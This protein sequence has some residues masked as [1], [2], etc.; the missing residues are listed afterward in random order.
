M[1]RRGFGSGGG[2]WAGGLGRGVGCGGMAWWPPPFATLPLSAPA[3][4]IHFLGSLLPPWALSCPLLHTCSAPPA[5]LLS[6][7]LT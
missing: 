4:L 6:P 7:T 3:K 5:P 1:R 2:L